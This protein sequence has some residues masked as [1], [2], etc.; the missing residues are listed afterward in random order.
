VIFEKKCDDPIVGYFLSN[1]KGIEILGT[2]TKF[3]LR[4][5]GPQEA[6]NKVEII[7]EQCLNLAAGEYSLNLGC[8]EYKEGE[9]IAHHRMYDLCIINIIRDRPV[10]GFYNPQTNIYINNF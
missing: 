2:N 10:V 3:T 1:K 7:F 5:L 9:L 8:S 6:G 4:D